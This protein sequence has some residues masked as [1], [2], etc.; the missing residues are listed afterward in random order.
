MA[1]KSK[2][3]LLLSNK[4]FSPAPFILLACLLA[5][6]P[7]RGGLTVNLLMY[8]TVAGVS[9]AAGYDCNAYL[10]TNSIPPD[11]PLGY[12]V[13]SSPT[14]AWHTEYQLTS[15]NFTTLLNLG[16]YYPDFDSFIQQ[17]TNGNWTIVVT[18][19]TSTNVYAFTVSASGFTSNVFSV[20]VV[21]S[22]PTN[23]AVNVTNQPTFT[24]QG[25]S[26]WSGDLQ[27]EEYNGDFSFFQSGD[28]PPAQT[29]WP[30]P[31]T[32]PA[33]GYTFYAG[34]TSN[35]S[36]LIVASTPLNTNTAAPI[37]GWISTATLETYQFIEFSV[38]SASGGSGRD[39]GTALNATNL[40]WTTSGATSWFVETTN[41]HDSVSAAQSGIV[42][43]NQTS[44]L[45]ATVTG[46]GTLTF[47]WSS[48]DDCANFDYE[49]DIDGSYADDIS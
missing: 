15:T 49:F 30:T 37:S 45:A 29:S 40:T 2:T 18:N 11:A 14:N 9:A 44:V 23:G 32:L 13:M 43:N 4:S 27:V 24:W 39:L 22:F 38:S 33:G 1:M 46:P 28:L 34:Y 26:P 20:P 48:H 6:P 31:A 17:V 16:H 41:T 3:A 36:P 5:A 25:P 19:A 7:A 21:V 12:Y 35:A 10:S 47:Y 8:H 42:T